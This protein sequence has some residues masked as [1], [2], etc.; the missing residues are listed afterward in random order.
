[1]PTLSLGIPGDA[2]MAVLLG[3]MIL[4][5][6]TPGPQFIA[7]NPQMFWGLVASFWIGNILLLILNIPFIGVWVRILA[8]PYEVLYPCI[9]F[10]ICIGVYSVNNNIFD[11]FLTIGFGIFG[12]CMMR[13][14]YPI[15]PIL[16][17]FV[18]GPMIEENFRRAMLVSGADPLIF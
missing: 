15:V 10:F 4:H 11:L 7:H 9:L 6:I 17:G 1:I 16:L 18:L 14:N 12:Y 2:M 13:F 5:G 3:A 8:I